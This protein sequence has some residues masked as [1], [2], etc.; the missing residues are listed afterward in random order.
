[1]SEKAEREREAAS[2]MVTIPAIRSSAQLREGNGR[3]SPDSITPRSTKRGGS[4]FGSQSQVQLTTRD[5]QQIFKMQ[6]RNDRFTNKLLAEQQKKEKH[7]NEIEQLQMKHLK[8]VENMKVKMNA[9]KDF[10]A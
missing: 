9:H 6:N 5:V 1:M 4:L 8:N 2:N 3:I 7:K 10:V